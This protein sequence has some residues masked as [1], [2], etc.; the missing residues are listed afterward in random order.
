[1]H[2][3]HIYGLLVVSAVA[4]ALTGLLGEETLDEA[5]V[6]SVRIPEPIT[7]SSLDWALP[8][9]P[10]SAPSAEYHENA[11]LLATN[12]TSVAPTTTTVPPTTT[13][14][15]PATTV[16]TTA[17]A[18][19]P[20]ETPPKNAAPP[21]PTLTAG[22]NAAYEAEFAAKIDGLRSSKGLAGL[23]RDGSL[24][25]EARAWA[26]QMAERGDLSHSNISRFVPP[27]SAAAENVGRGGSVSSLFD[28][29]AG[30]SG[31]LSNMLGGY[32]HVG[33]GVWVDG[34]GTL[35]T[36]HVFTG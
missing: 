22:F 15:A 32:T 17:P 8:M 36:A 21:Q 18:E 6:L 24:D 33:I 14:V 29:L 20:T 31:H 5:S 16:T 30:S 19:Q 26:Q 2:R 11:R 7:T 25:A 34:S 3:S 9:E 12:T 1:M 28:A 10:T 23:A 13:T 4:A 27:W 35:W